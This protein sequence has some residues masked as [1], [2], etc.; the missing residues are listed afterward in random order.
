MV[1]NVQEVA[2]I[3]QNGLEVPLHVWFDQQAMQ[4]YIA[5]QGAAIDQAPVDAQWPLD[6]TVVH[7][8]PARAGRQVLVDETVQDLTASLR[9][10]KPGA[11]SV[12]TRDL[13]PRLSDAAVAAAREQIE[14]M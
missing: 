7:T 6:G 13:S 2:A 4:R 12:R 1:E 5:A 3:W 11:I 9:T 14:A 8:Q 10:F